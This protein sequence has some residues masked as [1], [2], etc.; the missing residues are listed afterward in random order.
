MELRYNCSSAPSALYQWHQ[1]IAWHDSIANTL[2]IQVDNSAVSSL[3]DSGGAKDT[4]YPMMV[5]A[6][7]DGPTGFSGFIDELVYY[8]RVLTKNER[9]WFYNGG[10]GRT[11]I[12]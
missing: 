10:L 6:H 5:G 3:S 4:T 7:S 1:V 12:M 11:A 8:K 2:N 9:A